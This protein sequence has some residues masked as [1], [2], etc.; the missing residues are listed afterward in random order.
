MT[1]AAR[2]QAAIDILTEL[3]KTDQPADRLIRDFFRAR[4][5]AGSKDRAAVIDRVYDVLRHRQAF[6]W[7]MGSESARAL[8]LASVLEEGGDPDLLFTGST[9]APRQLDEDEERQ[10]KHPPAAEPPLHVVGEF[11]PF[12]EGELK[13]AFGNRLLHELAALSER[14]PVDLRANS[15]KATRDEV[16]GVLRGEGFDV[17]P[18][19]YAPDGLR[20]PSGS[21]GLDRTTAFT[22]GWFEIQDEA[23]QIASL[24]AGAKPGMRV[25]DMAAGAGGK[26]LAL[27]AAMRNEGEIVA[28]DPRISALK[29]LNLRAVRAGVT[30]VRIEKEPRGAFDIVFLDAP[31]SGSGTW[32]RQPEQRWKLT[33]KVLAERMAKQDELLDRAAPLVKPGGRLV[34]ATCSILPSE[35]QD[36]VAVFRERHPGFVVARAD[37]VWRESA[38]TDALPGMGEFFAASPYSTGTDGFFAAVLVREKRA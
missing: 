5:Y 36:R 6:A 25:L 24:L 31:C 34:Y 26:T 33:P 23:A 14:A 11:P 2:I 29:Q 3:A 16:L 18:A 15:L 30:C 12:L 4:R 8:V 35:N 1:P 21:S 9:F 22:N 28:N 17:T 37:N 32:R 27:A 19:P 20:L 38:G 13:R 10:R 7:R